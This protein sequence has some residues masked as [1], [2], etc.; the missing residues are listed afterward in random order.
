MQ[1]L[2]PQTLE[3]A[4]QAMS[5]GACQPLAGGTD[6]F[7]SAAAPGRDLLDLSRIDQLRG[8]TRGDDGSLRIG[9]TTSWA[10]I[11]GA[12]LPPALAALQ[13]AAREVGAI[14]IQQAATIGG[15]LCNASPAADGVPPLLVL[16]ARVE[17]ASGQGRRELPLEDFITGPRRTALESGELLTA[18][19]IPPQPEAAR[20]AFL[21]L[22][23]RR[24]LVISIAMVAALA[25]I[26]RG[27]IRDTRIAVGACSPVARRLHDLE[28]DLRGRP[29]GDLAAPDLIGPAHLAP[30]SPID[31]V[32]AD[33]AYR[34]EAA[35]EMIRRALK[36]A[37]EGAHG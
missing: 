24:Y 21:K 10:E 33:A 29:I 6:H 22:G 36:A 31:D 32:R 34:R 15:N 12:D 7:V 19:L 35:A 3:E 18:I 1:H 2:I 8:I 30:L 9:A 26:E 27:R 11:A 28:R 5:A 17:L 25:V 16:E 37:A 4:L 14:Q 20:S 23:S 13:Q